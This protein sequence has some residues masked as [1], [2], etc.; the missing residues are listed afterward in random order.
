[1]KLHPVVEQVTE[2]IRQRS[3][4][5]RSAYLAQVKAAANR[6]RGAD[7]MG[8]AN[9]A[10][11]FAA[12]P[13][14]DKFKVVA[15]KAPNIAIVN[16]YNDMLSAHAPLQHYPDLIKDEARLQG[17]TAQVA[18]G[19]PAM[20]D[21]VTQGTPGM[22]LSLFSRD[23]IAMAAAVS[24][25]HDVFDAALML[26]V[27]D[28]IVPGLLIG[29]LQ[30][31]HLPTVFVPA[32]PMSSGLS[33]TEKARVREQAAQGQVGREALLAAESAAYHGPGTCTFYG[34]ANSNQMLLEAMG[35]HV[36][37]TAFIHPG[38][39]LRL[40]LTREAVR[41]VLTQARPIGQVVDERSIV[42]A[43]VALLATG[44]STNHLIHWVAVARAAGVLI[45]WDDF[46]ALSQAV[47][48]LAR[49]YPNGSADVNQFQAAGGPGYVIRE[50]LDAGLMHPDVLTVRAGGLREFTR[51]PAGDAAGL[52]WQ[53]PGPSG[54]ETV[55]R[56]AA[57]PFSATGGLRLLQ[58]NLGR[59]VI[60][61]SAVP[62]DRHII[63]AAA[64]VFD[65]QEALLDAFKA[66][67]LER[68]VVCVVRWQGPQAN[69]MPEL[70]KLTPPLAVL[71]GKGFK[72]ALVTDG[73]MSGASGKVPA[74]IHV[75]PE[76]AAGGPLARVQDGDRIRLDAVDGTLQVRVG[77]AEW[78]ARPLAPMPETLRAANAVGMGRELFANLRR[79]ALKAEEGACTWL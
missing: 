22:E 6:D 45:D 39:G 14:N 67:E 10:H 75:S 27:C 33:N 63:E 5:T 46:A 59:S 41:T 49:V 43:M 16:A 71:Q 72:V 13:A 62:E 52:R 9:V 61:V 35:L 11:A 38:E 57:R 30:F 12:L 68:D 21:G 40:A 51:I 60:K 28:K 53:D 65:S 76:A 66:G 3:A 23:V 32:G 47:P 54:D 73:R 37:G 26:G 48:L 31:G 4:V 70:H 64:R 69:G 19:V 58:G 20:C 55:L 15:E 24:L 77:D 56:P 25:S 17:A 50:L 18:G 34:T 79:N 29:A 78:A 36:P 1:M 42:N 44:G 8:C 2:R 7:R 74:A